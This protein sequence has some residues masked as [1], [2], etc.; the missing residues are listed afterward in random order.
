MCSKTLK[1]CV[2]EKYVTSEG[3]REIRNP[4]LMVISWFF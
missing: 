4:S 2:L 1:E 3:Q